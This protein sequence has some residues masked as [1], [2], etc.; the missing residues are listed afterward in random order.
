MKIES[1]IRKS[2]LRSGLRVV[3]EKIPA[4]R[5]ISLGVWIDVG[6]R[7]ESPE[8]NGLSHLIEH[9]LFKGT[10]D[11]TAKQIAEALESVGGS[12]NAF[13]S[14]EQTC[15]TARVLDDQLE[16][17]VD[18]L[19]D[20][21]CH[22]KLTPT[23]LRMEKKVICEEIKEVA[24]TPTDRVHDVFAQTLWGDHPL[25]QPILGP[26][27]NVAHFQRQ[28]ILDYL[29]RNYVAGSIL[30]AA[31]GNVSHRRL[32]ELARK[33]FQFEGGTAP[34]APPAIQPTV[35]QIVHESGNGEQTH[36]CLGFPG[37]SFFS[38]LKMAALA[39]NTYLGG[40]MSSV[41]FQKIREQRGLA[42]SVYTFLDF[43][44]D[45]GVFGTYVGTDKKHIAECVAIILKE[46]ERLK[47]RRLSN[48]KLQAI[49]DQL[50]GQ[51]TLGMESTVAHM[52]RA[53]RQEL[54]LGEFRSLDQTLE[55]INRVSTSDVLKYANE[56]FDRSV[57]AMTTLGPIDE[58]A[59]RHVL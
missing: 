48:L 39:V 32:V 1:T 11:R 26:T 53:A 33:Y 9:M 30:I 27:E 45:A 55:D 4:V 49:K 40:G 20:L 54:Y 58:K 17:A 34:S 51:L 56:T 14:R 35:G 59:L 22:A 37:Q 5:S 3:T 6:A 19:A 41:L 24:D 12:L 25:G 57:L 43:Y 36:L 50:K 42:Y 16:K 13:T 44:R 8:E 15:Y 7:Y 28:F 2:T 21:T 18:V 31:S 29:K 23:D 52:N 38:P 46:L 47:K 10:K